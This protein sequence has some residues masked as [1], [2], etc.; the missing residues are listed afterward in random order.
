M[1]THP[2]A[3]D[4]LDGINVGRGTQGGVRRAGYEGW[5]RVHSP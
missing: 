2:E 4:C 1:Y 5:G 3:L